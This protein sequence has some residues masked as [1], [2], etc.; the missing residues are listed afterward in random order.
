MSE[1]SIKLKIMI[2][3]FPF[4][5]MEEVDDI[6]YT[7][8]KI[9]SQYYTSF[10][11]KKVLNFWVYQSNSE[12]G[13]WR[14]CSY[15]EGGIYLYKG[16][17]QDTPT[18]SYD[19]VQ[20]TLIHTKLQNFI[21]NNRG[22]IPFLKTT[23]KDPQIKPIIS[24]SINNV[25]SSS[26]RQILEEPFISCQRAIKCGRVDTDPLNPNTHTVINMYGV[27]VL[28]NPHAVLDAFS[29]KF[30]ELY[31][32]DYTS[33]THEG[34]YKYN[35]YGILIVDADIF[36]VLLKRKPPL[37]EGS[38][39]NVVKLFFLYIDL[40]KSFESE[41]KRV[42]IKTQGCL[43]GIDNVCLKDKHIAPFLLTVPD[44]TCNPLGLY[45]KYI[46]CGTFI[47]KL[48]DYYQPYDSIGCTPEEVEFGRCSRSYSYIGSRYD[49]LFP[50]NKI[51]KHWNP[52]SSSPL[53]QKLGKFKF[54]SYD[55]GKSK[56]RYRRRKFSSTIK[57]RINYS[58]RH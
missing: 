48:F 12:M 56:K 36:S 32:I 54:H 37:I 15:F 7:K 51:V 4:K 25:I 44:S 42:L 17:P 8:I 24:K 50:F 49:T 57:Y 21:N 41:E 22:N 58:K 45:S 29:R 20:S 39:C 10:G 18:Y 11:E 55:G 33:I 1:S 28:N 27:D 9:K 14:Y 3:Q 6:T 53:V 5:L 46:P 34:K 43:R 23:G 38:E 19:Y 47:C 16:D 31:Y 13:L 52:V 40:N 35:F 2:D 30:E 26:S